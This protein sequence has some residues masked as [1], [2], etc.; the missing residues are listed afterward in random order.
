MVSGDPISGD[1]YG[2]VEEH[3]DHLI[4][5]L[6]DID[7]I[8][9]QVL[10]F[11]NPG[12]RTKHENIHYLERLKGRGFLF[13]LFSLIYLNNILKN[14]HK[15]APD[16][17]HFQ[18]T[19]PLFCVA[20]LVAQRKY[21]AVLTVHGILMQETMIKYEGNVVYSL[22]ARMIEKYTF[23]KLD[24][25]I[26]VSPPVQEII[27]KIRKKKTYV[28]PNGVEVDRIAG[29]EPIVLEQEHA[30]LY[31]GGLNERKGVHVLIEAVE[32]ARHQIPDIH[33]LIAG[34]G[35]HEGKLKERVQGS[36]LGDNVTFLG[37]IRGD[38]RFSYLKAAKFL[39]LPSFWE[40]LPIVVLEGM[41]CG[42][43][44]VGSRVGGIPFLVH[45]GENGY[46]VQPGDAA[47]LARSMVALLENDELL[48]GMGAESL[49]RVQEFRWE[50]I[51][52]DT[53]STYCRIVNAEN[54]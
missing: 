31:M 29:I 28:V 22:L 20:A 47:S 51:A 42:K 1:Q 15:Y 6:F 16:V 36:G 3:T 53:Y 44:I 41:A 25:L 43:A 30:I 10:M 46:L 32:M 54:E 39:V 12:A 40:T 38:A 27:D 11:N 4:A 18:G 14:I 23:M 33:L 37:F 19:F 8:D 9:L 21:A 50:K 52:G 5:H 45:D 49:K 35:S 7:Q 2:G 34:A 17:V 48:A 26:V 13:P 24:N